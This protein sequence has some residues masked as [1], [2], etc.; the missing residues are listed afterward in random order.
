MAEQCILDA[1]EKGTRTMPAIISK[2]PEDAAVTRERCEKAARSASGNDK[3]ILS[4]LQ[5]LHHMEMY[6]QRQRV[7]IYEQQSRLICRD[8]EALL[9]H[10]SRSVA[11]KCL[12]QRFRVFH[13]LA[14]DKCRFADDAI[15]GLLA[16][17]ERQLALLHNRELSDAVRAW[18]DVHRRCTESPWQTRAPSSHASHAAV[19]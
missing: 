16:K 11:R 17:Q 19:L 14:A 9:Q 2:A 7:A 5:Q 6:L 18:F 10:S 15:A 8:V 1:L 12:L 3:H 4:T 13:A